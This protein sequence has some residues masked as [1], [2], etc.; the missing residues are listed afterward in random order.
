MVPHHRL[1]VLHYLIYCGF[2][3]V[4]LDPKS[5]GLLFHHTHVVAQVIDVFRFIL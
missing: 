4:F 1:E 2:K 3:I 5:L